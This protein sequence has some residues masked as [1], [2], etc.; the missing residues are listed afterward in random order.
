MSK[1]LHVKYLVK[2][3]KTPGVEA[4]G[5][6]NDSMDFITFTQKEF[7]PAGRN[8]ILARL[9]SVRNQGDSD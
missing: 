9:T 4:R 5:S 2:V 3:M 8:S 7:R 6:A 1:L